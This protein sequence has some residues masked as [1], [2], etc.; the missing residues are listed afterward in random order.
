MQL[1]EHLSSI[2]TMVSGI[3]SILSKYELSKFGALDNV[4]S[5]AGN[6]NNEDVKW[7]FQQ[8][9]FDCMKKLPFYCLISLVLGHFNWFFHRYTVSLYQ[10]MMGQDANMVIR[11]KAPNTLTQTFYQ[12]IVMI[13]T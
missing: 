4:D 1:V 6:H 2:N 3:E 10:K 8:F 5:I 13:A 11:N 7:T 12:M 9:S